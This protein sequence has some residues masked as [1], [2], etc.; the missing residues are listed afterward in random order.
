MIQRGG[1]S[2]YRCKRKTGGGQREREFVIVHDH[3]SVHDVYLRYRHAHFNRQQNS[4]G[5]REKSDQQ[6]QSAKRFQ[7]TCDIHELSRQS[8]LYKHLLHRGIGVGQLG[9]AVREEDYTEG[10]AEN[11]QAQGLK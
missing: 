4:S 1:A 7:D 10:Y 8:M 11:Q 3:D 5:T 6:K 9:I 2:P